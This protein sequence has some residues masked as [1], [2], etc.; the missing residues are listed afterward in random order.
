M[1]NDQ[2]IVAGFG[3]QGALSLGQ[4][5]AYVGLDEGKEV[6]WLPSYGS[7]MRGGTA[8]CAVNVSGA[9]VASPLIRNPNFLIVMNSPSLAKFRSALKP[10]G[11]LV[12]NSS[13]INED[14]GRDDVD[15]YH[16]PAL[17]IAYEESNPKG[18]NMVLLGAYIR[19]SGSI[20]LE[21]AFDYIEKTF[22]GSKAKYVDVN[23]K[24]VRRGVEYIKA[25][26][27]EAG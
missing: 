5:I 11:K 19:L 22:T 7:E 9:P 20:S 17:D 15:C 16:I 8:N 26:Y 3:G 21:G 6:S 18:L 1:L 13:L 23:K 24:L 4:I 14:A 2:I 25:N 12:I 27:E 10:G